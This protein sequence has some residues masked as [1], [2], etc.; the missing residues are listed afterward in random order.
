[1]SQK[2]QGR[3]VFGPEDGIRRFIR[4]V[5]ERVYQTTRRH[6]QH[7]HNLEPFISLL[8]LGMEN[9]M[10]HSRGARDGLPAVCPGD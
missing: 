2:S 5:L 9:W 7:G 10:L 6:V 8:S 3:R 4:N 1:M